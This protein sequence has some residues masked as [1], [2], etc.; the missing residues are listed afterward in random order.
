MEVKL[1]ESVEVARERRVPAEERRA[2]QPRPSMFVSMSAAR[3]SIA[4]S[5][6]AARPSIAVSVSA[7]HLPIGVKVARE[8]SVPAEERRAL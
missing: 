5:M 2:L 6:S 7:T 3:P 8:R 4:I 1:F